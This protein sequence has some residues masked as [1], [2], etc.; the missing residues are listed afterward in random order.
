[1]YA[2]LFSISHVSFTLIFLVVVVVSFSL[3]NYFGRSRMKA[4]GGR[5]LKLRILTFLPAVQKK[6]TTPM[7]SVLYYLTIV[8]SAT[9]AIKIESTLLELVII[10]GDPCG[11][12]SQKR[13][14]IVFLTMSVYSCVQDTSIYFR[15]SSLLLLTCTTITMSRSQV[16]VLFAA[17]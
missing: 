13:M 10:L 8:A 12:Q 15:P 4:K 9:L 17:F 14:K 3:L 6:K 16:D 2:Q 11:I 1:M 5:A 7:S